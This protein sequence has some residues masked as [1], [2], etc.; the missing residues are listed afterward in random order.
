MSKRIAIFFFLTLLAGT[1]YFSSCEKSILPTLSL[2]SDTLSFPAAASSLEQTV[3]TN[4]EWNLY[5]NS[6]WAS[7]DITEGEGETVVMVSVEENPDP[8]ARKCT[9][10]VETPTITKTFLLIQQ[11]MPE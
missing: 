8:V 1:F 10:T 3:I 4:V 9:V 7:I 6:N 11:G 2:A 5:P